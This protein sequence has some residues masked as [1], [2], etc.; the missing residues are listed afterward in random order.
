MAVSPPACSIRTENPLRPPISSHPE[1]VT[2][3]QGK[4]LDSWQGCP[5]SPVPSAGQPAGPI[6]QLEP[7]PALPTPGNP[8]AAILGK[9]M[10][11]FFF[12]FW[13]FGEPDRWPQIC[14][15]HFH[16][17]VGGSPTD[18][19][20]SVRHCSQICSFSKYLRKACS[21][22]GSARGARRG[23]KCRLL[24]MCHAAGEEKAGRTNAIPSAARSPVNCENEQFF[25][26]ESSSQASSGMY[27]CSSIPGE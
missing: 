16:G 27:F 15:M 21:T 3:P 11:F 6:S 12:L 23:I 1:A 7:A 4:H 18:S 20:C 2:E 5:Q 25:D 8:A 9:L 26:R 17:G 14:A 13:S 22:H 24:A 19:S 10:A